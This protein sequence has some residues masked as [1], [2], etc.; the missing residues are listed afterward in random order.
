[1]LCCCD[2][3]IVAS[4]GFGVA[5]SGVTEWCP[6]H[7]ESVGFVASDCLLNCVHNLLILAVTCVAVALLRSVN[8]DNLA[9]MRWVA[10]IIFRKFTSR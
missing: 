1:M 10:T 6:I 3:A 2:L 5:I 9:D 7:S 8:E 4:D